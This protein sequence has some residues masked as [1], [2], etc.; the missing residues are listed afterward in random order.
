MEG[1]GHR[2]GVKLKIDKISYSSKL[3]L[4]IELDYIFICV[5]LQISG[6]SS[7]SWVNQSHF[8]LVKRSNSVRYILV[9]SLLVRLL[10]I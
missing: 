9:R 7:K 4:G 1:S 2:S 5:Q 8:I 3:R 6:Y 10:Y